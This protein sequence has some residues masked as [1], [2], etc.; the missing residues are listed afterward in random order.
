MGNKKSTPDMHGIA[1]LAGKRSQRSVHPYSD[2]ADLDDQEN[3]KWALTERDIVFLSSQT[4]KCKYLFHDNFIKLRFCIY[5]QGYLRT[6][7]DY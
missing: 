3:K 6:T 7:L 5:E 1:A 4:G 2:T